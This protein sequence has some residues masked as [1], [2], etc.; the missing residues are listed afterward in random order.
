MKLNIKDKLISAVEVL[1]A[2][3]AVGC[4]WALIWAVALLASPVYY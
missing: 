3:T 4:G 2:V 1:G